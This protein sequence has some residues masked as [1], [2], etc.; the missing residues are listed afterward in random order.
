MQITTLN[1]PW[2]LVTTASP[3]R[4][5]DVGA[6]GRLGR[7]ARSVLGT[8]GRGETALVVL[9]PAAAPLVRLLGAD[10]ED[11]LEPHITL[12]YPFVPA[13]SLT[14]EVFAGVR[15]IASRHRAFPFELVG[16][17]RFPDVVYARPEPATPFLDLVRA[18]VER[19]P[20]HQPYGGRFAS[21]VPH[22]TLGPEADLAQARAAAGDLLPLACV[23]TEVSLVANEGRGRWR[24]VMVAPLGG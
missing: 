11:G 24:T 7:R 1:V 10:P 22:L 3:V 6:W 20:E 21:V 19:W 9:V 15:S 12:L 4:F 8:S 2:P 18:L 14:T 23:A 13:R 16:L 17:D 5:A